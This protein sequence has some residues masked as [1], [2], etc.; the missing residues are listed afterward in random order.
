MRNYDN[1]LSC[2]DAALY[3]IRHA[4]SGCNSPVFCLKS[5]V[6]PLPRCL[7]G[8]LPMQFLVQCAKSHVITQKVT[9]GK[10]HRAEGTFSF[11]WVCVTVFVYTEMYK[12][13]SLDRLKLGKTCK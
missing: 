2:D 5:V 4:D 7:F 8:D 12:E 1:N 3:L 13:R 9:H 10:S 11:L 6:F